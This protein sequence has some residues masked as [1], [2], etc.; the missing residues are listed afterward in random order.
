MFLIG[1]TVRR[2][3]FAILPSIECLF[4]PQRTTMTGAFVTITKHTT[5][6]KPNLHVLYIVE[7]YLNGA[8]EIIKRR[9]SEVSRCFLYLLRAL[10]T[11]LNA[12]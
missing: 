1:S 10:G 3:F 9:F 12:I 8:V 11:N 4:L 5:A 6:S 7:V 2:A